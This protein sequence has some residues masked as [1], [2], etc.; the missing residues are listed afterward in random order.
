MLPVLKDLRGKGFQCVEYDESEL[1]KKLDMRTKFVE[2]EEAQLMGLGN[3]HKGILIPKAGLIDIDS[4]VKFYELEFLRMG[5][6]IQYNTEVKEVVVEPRQSLGIPGEP[7]FWQDAI[8]VG[9]K[10]TKGLMRAKKTII[11]A[12][13]WASQLLDPIGIECFIKA[14]KR[15]LFSVK[16]NTGALRKLLFTKE[17]TNAGCL[18]FTIL[19]KPSAYIRPAP[20]ED[21]FWLAY[22]DEFPRAFKIEDN[23]EPEEN[24]YKYGL[25]QVL[26]KYF[27]QFT[28]CQPF[29]AFAGLYEINSIDGQPLIFE[30]NGLIVVGGAS[31]SGILKADAIGRIAEALHGDEAYAL[32]HGDKKFKVSDL[33]LKN[34]SVE[35][36]KLVI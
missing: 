14:K 21:A 13:A 34:R 15:Q 10:T 29:S 6:K 1:A 18:P 5:G 7:Y 30:E 3:V 4:L 24:F 22:A 19:P 9:V 16:A 27:P 25:Y 12:G 8:V 32:L 31:G 20:E 28:G 2:D 26:V 36:E 23:P 11:A 17:F 35:P 33:G